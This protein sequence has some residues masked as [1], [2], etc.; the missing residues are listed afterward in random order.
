MP[1]K[2]TT[3][4]RKYHCHRINIS[5]DKPVFSYLFSSSSAVQNYTFPSPYFS[6]YTL[7]KPDLMHVL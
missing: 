2:A 3:L 5:L 4:K 1:E 6:S 7:I